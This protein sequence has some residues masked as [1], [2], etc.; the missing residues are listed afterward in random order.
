MGPDAPAG[1]TCRR[2]PLFF[3]SYD[4][5]TS[6]LQSSPESRHVCPLWAVCRVVFPVFC[7][8]SRLCLFCV[9]YVCTKY[10]EENEEEI[11]IPSPQLQPK[12][13]KALSSPVQ[14]HWEGG[15]EQARRRVA[16]VPGELSLP[17]KPVTT[18]ANRRFC[19]TR[20]A[21]TS[22]S[23]SLTSRPRALSTRADDDQIRSA[24]GTGDRCALSTLSRDARP[25]IQTAC[26]ST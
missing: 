2:D 23:S 13:C 20:K 12:T 10:E 14:S 7:G 21:K 15:K 9:C 17:N 24:P 22:R 19:Q 26:H 5:D 8:V 25:P 6:R 11:M 16:S 3:A 18:K 4:P 1:W